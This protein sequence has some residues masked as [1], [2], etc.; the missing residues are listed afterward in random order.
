MNLHRILTSLSHGSR[1]ALLLAA[2]APLGCVAGNLESGSP[3]GAGGA[4]GDT[5]MKPEPETALANVQSSIKISPTLYGQNYWDPRLINAAVLNQVDASGVKI[6]RIGGNSFNDNPSSDDAGKWIDLIQKNTNAKV[7]LQVSSTVEG[8][9]AKAKQ[10]VHLLKKYVD[11]WEIGNEPDAAPGWTK[12]VGENASHVAGYIKAIAR[13]M[14]EEAPAIKIYGPA[15]AWFD[16]VYLERWIG[17]KNDITGHMD[18]PSSPYFIDGISYHTYQ[19]TNKDYHRDNALKFVHEQQPKNI[20]KLRTWMDAADAKNGRKDGHKLTWGMTEF[21]IES[22]D[23]PDAHNNNIGDVGPNSFLN[24]Q[25]FA[26]M[27]SLG[28]RNEAQFMLGWGIYN[29]PTYSNG[30]FK[31]ASPLTG[32]GYL[33]KAHADGPL[34]RRS[35]YQH[36]N[37]MTQ[38]FTGRSLK[39]T[40]TMPNVPVIAALQGDGQIAV[41]VLNETQ[42]PKSY[43]VRLN[44]ADIGPNADAKLNVWA[45][46]KKS[47]P[48]DQTNTIPAETTLM[49]IFN[50]SGGLVKKISYSVKDAINGN[51]PG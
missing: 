4:G 46:V 7:L 36:T 19:S 17:G 39:G 40:S 42:S 50:A 29:V 34:I 20:N 31:D 24:G 1:A 21:N 35:S 45:G 14:R 51:G 49:L 23:E 33:T 26:E 48:A 16:E 37:L 38:Y 22:S 15:T 27:Y 5:G 8:A 28:M 11:F 13:A 10:M 41:M 12:D 2:L 32:V 44:E 30:Q 18:G 43:V 9:P 6:I 47:Y 25:Y 3:E